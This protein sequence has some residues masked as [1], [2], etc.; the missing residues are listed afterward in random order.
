MLI[1]PWSVQECYDMRVEFVTGDSLQLVYVQVKLSTSPKISFEAMLSTT[2]C[3]SLADYS[4]RYSPADVDSKWLE[5]VN[6][7]IYDLGRDG[8]W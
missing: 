1:V 2:V 8:V 7:V 5:C 6:V 3:Y 4:R